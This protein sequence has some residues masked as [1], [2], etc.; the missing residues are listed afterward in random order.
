MAISNIPKR[1][2][3]LPRTRRENFDGTLRYSGKP[4]REKREEQIKRS[5]DT[6]RDISIGLQDID[7]AIIYYFK[8]V[9][10]PRV[11]EN[12]LL[13]DVPIKYGDPEM[14]VSAQKDGYLRDRKGKVITP[15]VMYRRTSVARNDEIPVDKADRNLVHYFPKKWSNE[16]NKYDRFSITNNI[17]PTYEMYNIVVPDYVLITYECIIWTSFVTQMNKI[18]EAMQY[19]EGDYWGD[20]EKFK[21]Q[22]KIDSF[23]MTTELSVDKGRMVR[24]NFTLEIRGFLVPEVANDLLT[25]QKEFTK[26]RIILET[27]TEVDVLSVIQPDPFCEKIIVSTTRQPAVSAN[28]T[29]TDLVNAKILQLQLQVNYQNKLAVYSTFTTP[30][31]TVVSSSG[32]NSIATYPNVY[33]ASIPTDLPTTSTITA[34][35]EDDFLVFVNGQYMEHDAFTIQQSGSS[36][37]VIASEG[38]LGYELSTEDEIVT[39]GKFD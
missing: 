32:G 26:Q 16:H 20:D 18:V 38:S 23:D 34:T 31:A 37:V 27:E 29:I 6:F 7:E 15:I 10:K 33:T 2:K 13:I 17:K 30:G 14:W 5:D 21:F 39:W 8:N 4:A 9:I 22:S 3:P 1:Q 25:T 36:F 28:Q 35:I 12:G 24:S 11:L 19:A